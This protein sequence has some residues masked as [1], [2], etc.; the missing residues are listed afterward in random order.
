MSSCSAKEDKVCGGVILLPS[1]DPAR[2]RRA[3]RSQFRALRSSWPGR[4]AALAR[5]ALTRPGRA[6]PPELTGPT[7]ARCQRIELLRHW[8]LA[9][10]RFRR[11]ALS[12]HRR[13]ALPHFQWS[14][15]PQHLR[16]VLLRCWQPL[17]PRKQ[18]LPRWSG[19]LGLLVAGASSSGIRASSAPAATGA[20]A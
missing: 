7:L 19:A 20:A 17:M 6:A 4:L 9:L 16:P 10:L 13:P 18:F 11:P 3:E 5:P 8:R 2:R 1:A 12:W 14:A 15:F